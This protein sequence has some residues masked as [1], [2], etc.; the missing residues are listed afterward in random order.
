MVTMSIENESSV[1]IIE[2]FKRPEK[3]EQPKMEVVLARSINKKLEG[4]RVLVIG[5]SRGLGELAVKI[6][7][8]QGAEVLFS[9]RSGKND[10]DRIVADVGG[11][12][13]CFSWN[14]DEPIFDKIL[15][16]NP[17]HVYYMATPYI[18]NK[19]STV[20]VNEIF[21]NFHNV[22]NLCFNK[23]VENLINQNTHVRFFWPSTVA[24]DENTNTLCEYVMA[25]TA[26]ERLVHYLDKKY[27]NISIYTERLPK[28]ET[29]QTVTLGESEATDSLDYF[30]EFTNRFL[31]E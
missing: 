29:D 8:A 30:I 24:I 7:V 14:S 31:N 12:A 15:E 13:D 11:G 18:F 4:K 21:E 16:F 9:Y 17:T 2:A 20:F 10:A 5:G 25:K 28:L 23:L 19:K 3:K 27:K 22:Y 6:S 26:G 1:V